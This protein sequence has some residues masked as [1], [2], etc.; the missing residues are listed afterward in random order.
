MLKIYYK[1]WISLFVK[2]RTAQNEN[3]NLALVLSLIV[4]TICG[5]INF[6]LI[7]YLALIFYKI[8][9][10]SI[11]HFENKYLLIFTLVFIFLM[12]NYL[13][14]IF[15]KKHERLLLTY[16]NR[17]NKNLGFYYFVT[18]CFLVLFFLILMIIFPSFFGLNPQ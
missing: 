14:L 8:N 4:M 1:I 16:E 3:A 7:T 5:I 18:S 12:S 13:L 11:F 15:N 10:F 2:V 6:F 17:I 9:L